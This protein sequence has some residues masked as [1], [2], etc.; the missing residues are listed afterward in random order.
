M[1]KLLLG[2]VILSA[3]LCGSFTPAFAQSGIHTP[4]PGSAER[5]AVLDTLRVPVQRELKMPVIFVVAAEPRGYFRVKQG[6][7]FVVAEFRHPN[8]DPMGPAYFAETHGGSSSDACGLLHLVHGRW[9]IV[10]HATGP[11]DVYWGGWQH[12]YHL[13]AGLVPRY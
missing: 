10:D 3:A 2:T 9:H 1:S 12:D 6:W 5:K 11:S 4:K 7:A 13:P 8:G